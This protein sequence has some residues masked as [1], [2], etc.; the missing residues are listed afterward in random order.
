M[1]QNHDTCQECGFITGW[2]CRKFPLDLV[3]GSKNYMGL[4]LTNLYDSQGLQHVAFFQQHVTSPDITGQLLRA[5]VEWAQIHLGQAENIFNL[6]FKRYGKLLPRSFIKTLWEYCWEN[7]ISILTPTNKLEH[8][9]E[10][11]QF[12]M[13]LLAQIET[14]RQLTSSELETLNM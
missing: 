5:A 12:I 14:P 7:K 8:H 6:D 11:D 2:N 13:T 1:Y 3:Y 10:G 4:G 9:R